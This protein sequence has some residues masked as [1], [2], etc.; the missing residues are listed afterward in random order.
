MPFQPEKAL[1]G[2][3]S[4]IVKTGCGTDGALHS[5]ICRALQLSGCPGG[6]ILL[7]SFSPSQPIDWRAGVM[8]DA[9]LNTAQWAPRKPAE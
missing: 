4:V 3:F 5:N 6:N 1:V 8:S 9:Y 2:G 7:L